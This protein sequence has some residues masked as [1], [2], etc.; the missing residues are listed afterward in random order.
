MQVSLLGPL[1]LTADDQDQAVS[2]VRLAGVL[3]ALA[4]RAPEPLSVPV[5]IDAVWGE[6]PPA[7]ARNTLQAHVAA[8]R[9]L[10]GRDALISDRGS[11][12][13]A[14]PGE[15][16]DVHRFDRLVT[17]GLTTAAAGDLQAAARTLG[18]ALS[19][20]RSEPLEGLPGAWF[21]T[22]RRR[23]AAR[24]I[25][26]LHGAI[27]VGLELG[28][29]L[30]LVPELNSLIAEHPYD[31]R[32]V[33]QQMLALYRS[34]RPTDALAAYQALQDRLA[35]DLGTDPGP[36][37]RQLH[38][39]I[40]NHAPELSLDPMA[41]RTPWRSPVLR[42]RRPMLGRESELA[43]LEQ[44]VASG[45][46][47]VTLVGPSGI[48]KTRLATEVAA[49]VQGEFDAGS[50]VIAVPALASPDALAE[51]IVR[52]FGLD[53]DDE[54]LTVLRPVVGVLVVDDLA[55]GSA[56]ATRLHRLLETSALRVVVTARRPM[57]WDMEE[58]RR[59]EPLSS[60][61]RDGAPGPATELL[62]QRAAA[63]GAVI[64]RADAEELA[65][66]ADCARLLDGV[67]LALELAA[68]R[69]IVGFGELRA[70]LERSGGLTGVQLSFAQTLEHLDDM[71]LYLLRV[72]AQCKGVVD[73]DWLSALPTPG[74]DRVST[75]VAALV[76]DG[77]IRGTP[78]SHGRVVFDLLSG[79]RQELLAGM[80]ADEVVEAKRAMLRAHVVTFHRN[81]RYLPSYVD[82]VACAQRSMALL[83]ALC[84]ALE[85][86]IDLED[87]DTVAA[88]G[89]PA[90]EM[91]IYDYRTDV[92]ARIWDWLAARPEVLEWSLPRQI[93]LRLAADNHLINTN[94]TQ[95]WRDAT[96][97]TLRLAQEV[98]DQ[99][100]IGQAMTSIVLGARIMGLPETVDPAAALAI[101][102][103]DP[104]PEVSAS[105]QAL[106][107]GMVSP[108]A[109]RRAVEAGWRANHEGIR[110]LALANLTDSTLSRGD[111]AAAL[112][113]A[114]EATELAVQMHN[115]YFADFMRAS[116]LTAHAIN[117][118]P[119]H[120]EAIAELAQKAWLARDV[121]SV[122]D[123]L[124]K[125][126][127]GA[128]NCG[129]PEL[130]AASFGVFERVL[131]RANAVPS[132]DEEV[133][134]KNWLAEVAP[135][136][137]AGPMEVVIAEL[138]ER[139]A[140]LS[141]SVGVGGEPAQAQ[142]VGDHR[143]R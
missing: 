82:T 46:Q 112:V 6:S 70:E 50:A 86:A 61:S 33:A 75:A 39:A 43:G 2:G 133:F 67:P 7:T 98:G 132:L 131:I 142:A 83:P 40:L 113:T 109:G 41:P 127:A 80:S 9:R 34:A 114:T 115:R 100:R 31:E 103:A 18:A 26:G 55:P 54:P 85:D 51:Q 71:E 105:T 108:E 49:R 3:A 13:L 96:D 8:L 90:S 87:V 78:G 120:L 44:L 123:G 79:V 122:T 128:L 134:I 119:V 143:H 66:A 24:R 68:P 89:A 139:C 17:E 104:C 106:I 25:E 52:A 94:D 11:Y 36:H 126:A 22:E 20:W 58:V 118:S 73:A 95:Q 65:A 38:V 32:L 21:A 30:T 27:D 130:A 91:C 125:L 137:P 15:A 63:A 14:L 110:M 35:D 29:H 101:A 53:L 28:R 93:D 4:L 129:S 60:E 77:L 16:I 56:T 23:L 121:R 57:G 102:L 47:V 81:D 84:A 10:L 140:D 37:L 48:G 45:A 117:G 136:S 12:R 59:V 5:L 19:L 97:L 99:S 124:L 116:L 92:E 42:D 76:R 138:R 74:S 107:G 88:L 141:G 135:I 62:L 1:R 69:A 64:D 72:L 111:A